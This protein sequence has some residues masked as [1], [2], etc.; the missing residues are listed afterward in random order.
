MPF[1]D[2]LDQVGGT[3][4]FQILHV[5]LLCNNSHSPLMAPMWL[6]ESSRW[7]A[8]RNKPEQA[9]KNLKRVAKF[10]GRH[11]EGEQIDIKMLQESMKKEISCSQ[12]SYSV[13]DLFRTPS[14]RTMTV[15]L[16]A[17]WFS[18]SF[19]YYGIAMDLQKFGVDIYLIQVIFGAVDLPAKLIICVS[20]DFIGRRR[21][22][23]GALIISGV[24]I[25]INLLVPYDK[26]TA[27]TCLAVLGKG[28]LA[29][30][31]NCCYLYSGELY[32]T[33]IRQNGM[34]WVS[35]TARV[36][37][38]VAPMVLLTADFIPWLP[39]LIYG[40]AAILSGVAAIFLPETLGLPLLD[41]IQ[42]VEDRDLGES[43][44]CHQ[45]KQT[46]RRISYSR[47]PE[48]ICMYS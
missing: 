37:A 6:Y 14:M 23:F 21:S 7:L 22:Q 2:L 30:S 19:A 25:L 35:M 32:P 8:L 17:V 41:T 9:V 29:A 31:F 42:D 15:F 44:K 20:M 18:T 40:G 16:S 39:G 12:G 3:G 38:M 34:G 4:R 47:L 33:I 1:G 5:T 28:C 45:R 26:Q 27:R 36:R 10:N 48:G 11:E 43:L 13:L 46:P 24:A